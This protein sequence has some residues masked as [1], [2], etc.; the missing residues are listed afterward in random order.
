MCVRLRTH[1]RWDIILLYN[2]SDACTLRP[3]L[4]SDPIRMP[5]PRRSNVWKWMRPGIHIKRW[6]LLL[7]AGILTIIIS[8]EILLFDVLRGQTVGLLAELGG[9]RPWLA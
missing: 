1:L 3:I 5:L 8:I 2:R 7:V 9:A 6:V 4:D